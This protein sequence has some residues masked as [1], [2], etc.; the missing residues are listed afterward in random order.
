MNPYTP[1]NE[2][3]RQTHVSTLLHK[4]PWVWNLLSVLS[5][6]A[7][8]ITL[9]FGLGFS[10]GSLRTAYDTPIRGIALLFAVFFLFFGPVVTAFMIRQNI[11]QRNVLLVAMQAFVAIGWSVIAYCLIGGMM[12]IF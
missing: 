2:H 9:F 12:G 1:P 5:L 6:P 10:A 11:V 7:F 4:R 8:F 3:S